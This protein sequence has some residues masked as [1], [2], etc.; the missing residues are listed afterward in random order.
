MT[1]Q[2]PEASD[3]DGPKPIKVVLEPGRYAICACGTTRNPPHCDGSHAALEQAVA[4]TLWTH[5]G[6]PTRIAWCTCRASGN[7]PWCDG[8][9]RNLA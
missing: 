6:E 8:S 2:A 7:L 5:E 9:H 3:S 1:A 4:P